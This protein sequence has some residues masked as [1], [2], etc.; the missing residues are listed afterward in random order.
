MLGGNSAA[1]TELWLEHE[2]SQIT[3]S[4]RTETGLQL[5]TTLFLLYFILRTLPCS[6]TIGFKSLFWKPGEFKEH[7]EPLCVN[8]TKDRICIVFWQLS[9]LLFF[10]DRPIEPYRGALNGRPGNSHEIALYW[11]YERQ[12]DS[13]WMAILHSVFHH[14]HISRFS[15]YS[16]Q[17]LRSENLMN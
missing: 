12:V 15:L 9:L 3:P 4:R 5:D 11:R 10:L 14:H 13:F 6:A 16:I 8:W 1:Q 17:F 2:W 7:D